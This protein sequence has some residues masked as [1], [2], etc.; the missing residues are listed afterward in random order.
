MNINIILPLSL[1]NAMLNE[2]VLQKNWLLQRDG[3]NSLKVSY[4][5]VPLLALL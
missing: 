2:R 3:K 1:F 5:S 4:S